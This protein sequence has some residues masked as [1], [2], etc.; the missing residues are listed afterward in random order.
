MR[1][2]I[3]EW[4]SSGMVLLSCSRIIHSGTKQNLLC[5]IQHKEMSMTKL[6]GE[7]CLFYL[8]CWW[9]IFSLFID[10]EHAY[11]F[12]SFSLAILNLDLEYAAICYGWSYEHQLLYVF[13][14]SRA[15]VACGAIYFGLLV[16]PFC[17]YLVFMDFPSLFIS[18]SFLFLRQCAC[19]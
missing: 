13:F 14:F 18:A 2:P 19:I 16:M 11:Y 6:L 1:M 7:D 10:Q 4:L 17:L 15:F 3:V 5:C 9:V 8:C 12:F